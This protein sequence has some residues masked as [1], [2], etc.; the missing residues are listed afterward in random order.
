MKLYQFLC[1]HFH[2]K[3][4]TFSTFNLFIFIPRWFLHL[5]KYACLQ[6]TVTAIK[7]VGLSVWY[8]L[9]LRYGYYGNEPPDSRHI[10]WTWSIW[11][12]KKICDVSWPAD[13]L[14]KFN[15]HLHNHSTV[16]LTTAFSRI[17]FPVNDRSLWSITGFFSLSTTFVK[18]FNR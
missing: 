8:S 1:T 13:C 14:A 10:C 5:P 6:D 17:Q 2:R 15:G 3:L 11:Q 9:R 4:H 7:Y 12:L 16:R 18:A